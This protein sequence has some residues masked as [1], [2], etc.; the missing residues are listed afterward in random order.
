VN[1]GL[2]Q[3]PDTITLLANG[4][5][6]TP[7]SEGVVAVVVSPSLVKVRVHLPASESKNCSCDKSKRRK[8]PGYPGLAHRLISPIFFK[9]KRVF[10][11]SALLGLSNRTHRLRFPGKNPDKMIVFVNS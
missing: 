9:I 8:Q 2:S 4:A 7:M 6:V 3:D 11:F 10:P 5:G 1:V